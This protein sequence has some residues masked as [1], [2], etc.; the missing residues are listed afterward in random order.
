MCSIIAAGVTSGLAA[1][2]KTYYHKQEFNAQKDGLN[3]EKALL[4]QIAENPTSKAAQNVNIDALA[5]NIQ[6]HDVELYGKGAELASD[7][8]GLVEKTK[9]G[10]KGS[11]SESEKAVGEAV[12]QS[13]E[14]T[15]TA[16]ESQQKVDDARQSVQEHKS[17]QKQSADSDSKQKHPEEHK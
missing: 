7:V 12:S 2:A 9:I 4:Q 3:A 10:A 16:V 1:L 5:Q 11:E 14:F 8:L 17:D 15:R 6:K 13:V